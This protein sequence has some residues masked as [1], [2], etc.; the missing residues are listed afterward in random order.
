MGSDGN[1]LNPTAEA[2]VKDDGTTSWSV[3]NIIAKPGSEKS[4]TT[5]D[6]GKASR[7]AVGSTRPKV[8][9]GFGTA[10]AFK[11]ID[12][13]VSFDYQ[14]GG[15]IYDS[16]YRGL[17]TPGTS[18]SDAGSTFHRDILNAWSPTNKN[19]DIPRWQYG[20]QYASY[21]SDRFLINA[22][23]LNF[24]SFTVGYTLPRSLTSKI[25]IGTIRVYAAGE[26]LYLWSKRKGLDPR[27]SFQEVTS[28]SS[29]SPVRTISGG[30]QV[31]F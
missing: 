29:Y 8:Y 2:T 14:L 18:A 24:Q 17:M 11:G 10:L 16:A 9:G 31:T 28:I 21:G 6:I 27:Q 5:T 23:Y 26:N 12:V 1:P 13:S 3:T 4:G 22:S 30:L 20:D 19:S 7:Y 25:R 15:K